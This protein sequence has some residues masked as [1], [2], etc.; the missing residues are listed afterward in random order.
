MTT[1]PKQPDP[2]ISVCAGARFYFVFV[3][4]IIQRFRGIANWDPEFRKY[5]YTEPKV[6][7][8]IPVL[9]S[10]KSGLQIKN[11]QN[12]LISF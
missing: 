7:F 1:A 8:L 12:K 10:Y 9:I 2:S 11:K 4:L 6:G 3:K 5:R